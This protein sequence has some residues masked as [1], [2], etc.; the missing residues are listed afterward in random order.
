MADKVLQEG[1][2]EVA[3]TLTLTQVDDEVECS[4]ESGTSVQVRE[5]TASSLAPLLPELRVN[6]RRTVTRTGDVSPEVEYTTFF[7]LGPLL[8]P[9]T[10]IDRNGVSLKST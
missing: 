5:V 3:L 8:K 6:G 10:I 1:G 4:L 9:V 7:L 2:L